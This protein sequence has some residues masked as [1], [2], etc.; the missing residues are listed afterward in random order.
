MRALRRDDDLATA[1]FLPAFKHRI[2]RCLP[3]RVEM[4]FGL[5]NENQRTRTPA[6]VEFGRE[7][8]R[9]FF[10]AAQFHDWVQNPCVIYFDKK[11]AVFSHELLC[12]AEEHLEC[13][14]ITFEMRGAFGMTI[15]FCIEVGP[16]GAVEL[17]FEGISPLR[18][19][20]E[21][22]KKRVGWRHF[23]RGFV[24]LWRNGQ[25]SIRW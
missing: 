8:E 2:K 4:Q 16:S 11:F 6:S 7:N 18:R 24:R 1:F 15:L 19:G 10:A 21:L 3:R 9:L 17:C 12:I 25:A 5:V 20:L 22:V 23:A 14:G 13:F